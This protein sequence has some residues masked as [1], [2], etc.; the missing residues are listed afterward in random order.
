M[1]PANDQV[2][3][4]PSCGD[5]AGRVRTYARVRGK[6]L[7][8]GWTCTKCGDVAIDRSARQALR[9]AAAGAERGERVASPSLEVKQS[10]PLPKPSAGLIGDYLRSSGN[11][12]L[13]AGKVKHDPPRAA[14]QQA[15]ID[16]QRQQRQRKRS[17]GQRRRTRTSS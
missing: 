15:R 6:W 11:V 8:I 17:N 4:C 2:P 16:K 9:Q 1:R 12:I 3:E 5:I 13:A 7:P 14:E 10:L